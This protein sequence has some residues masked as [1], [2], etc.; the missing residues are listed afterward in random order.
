MSKGWTSPETKAAEE[1]AR[2]L[3]E[4][5]E[6]LGEPIEDPLLLFS[7]LYGFWVANALAFN[8]DVV[9]ELAAQFLAL[10]E[11]Q[12]ETVP[13][14]IGHRIMGHSLLFTGDLAKSRTHY[15]QAIALYDP[16]LHRPLAMRFGQDIG[17]TILSYRSLARW[18]LGCPD[19]A[20]IDADH[21]V[22]S[23]REISQAPTLMF[24]LNNTCLTQIWCGNY[25]TANAQVTELATL[26]EEKGA[27]LWRANG[28]LNRGHLLLLTS[29]AVHAV[30]TISSG[31]AAF[32]STGS[33]LNEPSYL[34]LLA[35]A[36][37]GAWQ[38]R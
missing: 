14:M 25:S 28:L 7:V 22:R 3:I 4:Q 19:A 15:D 27:D 13:L 32:R 10:A 11:K 23:A 18:M 8:G 5:A 38:N 29:E 36:Y 34:S 33:T 17:V 30:K 2:L 24:A 12:G 9:R 20:L 31:L 6:A 35:V 26:A 1:R 21:A 37:A 16:T